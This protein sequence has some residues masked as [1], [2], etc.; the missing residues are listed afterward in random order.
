LDDATCAKLKRDKKARH[1]EVCRRAG[2]AMEAWL[3]G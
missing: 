3:D 1:A 2:A